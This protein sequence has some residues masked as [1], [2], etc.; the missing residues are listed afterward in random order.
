[1][2]TID[3]DEAVTLLAAYALDALASDE[4]RAAV[5]RHLEQCAECRQSLVSYREVAAGLSPDVAPPPDLWNRIAGQLQPRVVSLSGRQRATPPRVWMGAAAAAVALVVGI[6]I[7]QV[8]GNDSD[9]SV[10]EIA[11]DARDDDGASVLTLV[12]ADGGRAAEAVLT[13]D[14]RGFLTNYELPE[15]EGDRGYQLW[16]L[17]DGQPISVALLGDDP[18]VEAF[19][20]PHR[21]DQLLITEEPAIG[22]PS[23]TT[24]PVASVTA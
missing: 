23:P 15:L 22:S 3:H 24:A 5:D 10:R 16:A 14:G 13:A 12:D 7:G 4:E 1:M 21:F 8:T 9:S 20:A 2:I 17:R 18:G 19:R 11:A 6:A